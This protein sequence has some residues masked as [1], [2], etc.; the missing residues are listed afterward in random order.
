M[1]LT[2]VSLPFLP[3]IP[4]DPREFGRQKYMVEQFCRFG[5]ARCD[6]KYGGLWKG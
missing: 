6:A 3:D 5:N 2:D 1:V 4:G